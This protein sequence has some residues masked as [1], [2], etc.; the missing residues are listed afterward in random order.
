[1]F[2]FRRDEMPT[3]NFLPL[4]K[5]VDGRYAGKM[6]IYEN[7]EN[8]HFFGTGKSGTGKSWTIAQILCML[9]MLGQNVVVLDVSKTYTKEKLYRMLP[10]D[11]VDKLFCFIAVGAGQDHIPIDLG[12]L[13]GC[14]NLWDKKGVIY[15]TLAAAIGKT[16]TDK[17]VDSLKKKALQHFLSD[18]LRDKNNT[19]DFVDMLTK[20]E[21]DGRVDA[22]IIDTLADI[23]GEIDEIGY[24]RIS[25]GDLFKH[26]KK[27]IVLDLGNEVGDSS[28]VLLDILAA[29]LFSWQML[30][31]SEFLT[32][33]IDELKDQNFAPNSILRS[34]ITDGRRFH[35]ALIGATQDYF[36]QRHPQL[37]AMRQANIKSF[38]RPGKS[39][40]KIA[41]ELGFDN[42]MDAGFN[43]F[44]SGDVILELD[45]FNKETGANEPTVLRG[46]V[47]DFVDTLLYDRFL[48]EYSDDDSQ[49]N[50][51]DTDVSHEE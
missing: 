34:I 11:V 44:K 6:L 37:D 14:D 29:S 22:E 35:T 43:K 1:M 28:H 46:K 36:D 15:R 3:E 17:S 33:A 40:D 8:N 38:C 49:K 10:Q 42:A 41:Q 19:V 24:D 26:E 20:M 48:R 23:L 4:V 47:V 2:L 32:I 30:H 13:E 9:R 51:T 50:N 25:W 45:A 27:I 21:Q 39:E 12:A 7:E 31:D 5:I 18:Y 16:D